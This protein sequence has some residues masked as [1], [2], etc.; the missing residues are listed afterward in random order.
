MANLFEMDMPLKDVDANPA[1]NGATVTAE[2]AREIVDAGGAVHRD[3][4]FTGSYRYTVDRAPCTC[5][6]KSNGYHTAK[7]ALVRIAAAKS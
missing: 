5:G 7:C 4:R 3:D 6:L 1:V 2:R